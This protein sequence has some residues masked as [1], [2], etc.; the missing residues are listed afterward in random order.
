MHFSS[1][2]ETW[3]LRKLTCS[4]FSSCCGTSSFSLY[5]KCKSGF[6]TYFPTRYS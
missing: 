1:S 5:S 2:I 6:G 4:R 3:K